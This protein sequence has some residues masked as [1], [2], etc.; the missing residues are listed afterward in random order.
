MSHF[1]DGLNYG[2]SAAKPKS[3]G[4]LLKKNTKEVILGQKGTR[5]V[6]DGKD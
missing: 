3:N 5:M 1:F 6:E 2:L 4:L